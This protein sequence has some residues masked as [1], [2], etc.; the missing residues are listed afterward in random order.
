MSVIQKS[1][2]NKKVSTRRAPPIH[3][4][5]R[6]YFWLVVGYYL[7]TV[8]I[9]SAQVKGE[10][11]SHPDVTTDAYGTRILGVKP[12]EGIPGEAEQEHHGIQIAKVDFEGVETPFIIALWIFCASLAKIGKLIGN[13]ILF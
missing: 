11:I 8:Y 7:C 5:S 4:N 12:L 3:T 6:K 2:S 9:R 13:Y 1:D 10:S